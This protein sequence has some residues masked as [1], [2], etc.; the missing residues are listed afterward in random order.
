VA[1]DHGVGGSSPLGDT[2]VGAWPSLVGR[3]LGVVD[4][5]GSNP[6]APIFLKAS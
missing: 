6:V 2:L 5:A 1:T 4:I 3:H